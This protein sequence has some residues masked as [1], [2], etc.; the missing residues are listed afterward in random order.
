MLQR[1]V[2]LKCHGFL[3]Y[4]D[5]SQQLIDRKLGPLIRRLMTKYLGELEDDDLILFSVE[6][7]KDHKSP[8]SLVDDL[9]V[10]RI[11]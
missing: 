11:V 1:Y 9:K 2:L 7:L 3:L 5:Q 6:H 4:T 10:V 8:A